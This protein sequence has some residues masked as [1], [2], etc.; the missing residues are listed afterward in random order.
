MSG[1]HLP[2]RHFRLP[3]IVTGIVLALALIIGLAGV[4][5]IH[6]AK[7]SDRRKVERAKMLGAGVAGMV[8]LVIAPFWLVGAAKV[9]RERRAARQNPPA[10]PQG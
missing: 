2:K 8:C 9:G 5:W 4:T 6:R 10:T 7:I 1:E 3:L